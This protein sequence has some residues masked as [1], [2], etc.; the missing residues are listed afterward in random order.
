[1]CSNSFCLQVSMT[2]TCIQSDKLLVIDLCLM[3]SVS[4]WTEM[5]VVGLKC[6]VNVQWLPFKFV[7]AIANSAE[8]AGCMHKYCLWWFTASC[9]YF[10]QYLCAC[11]VN[12]A[13]HFLHQQDGSNL[14]PC[15][16]AKLMYGVGWWVFWVLTFV[17]FTGFI[18]SCNLKILE[19]KSNSFHFFA[20]IIWN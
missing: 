18:P 15:G 10:F 4:W 9:W 2:Q 17:C 7:I 5:T 13:T 19:L 11:V 3:G 1:M 20:C 8:L 6:F 14:W 12:E 16:L